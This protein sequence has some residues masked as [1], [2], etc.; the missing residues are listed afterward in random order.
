M[1]VISD[2]YIR[3][4]CTLRLMIYYPYPLHISYCAYAF[5]MFII[6]EIKHFFNSRRKNSKN[7][8]NA[9]EGKLLVRTILLFPVTRLA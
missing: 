3:I 1:H 8:Q 4:V 5:D 2:M 6:Q 7:I 9:A